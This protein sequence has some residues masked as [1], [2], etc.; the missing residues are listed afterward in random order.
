MKIALVFSWPSVDATKGNLLSEWESKVTNELM[1]QAG[2]VPTKQLAAYPTHV[3]KPA[4][5]FLGKYYT[6]P[7]MTTL[8]AREKLCKELAGFDIALTM[9]TFAMWALTGETKLDIFRG[10]HIDSPFVPGLQVV[11][12]YD[13]EVFAR[14][15][16]SARPVVL[17]AMRKAQSKYEDT[18][19]DIY[20]PESLDDLTW[21]EKQFIRDEIAFDVE[22]NG[23]S[24]IT[25]FSVVPHEDACLYVALE[26][27]THAS[28]H[29]EPTELGI[30]SWLNSLAR[31]TDL[32]W[33][34][35]NATYDL[36]YLDAYGIH[37]LGHI[38]D[39]M[40]VHHAWQPEWEKSLGF[41]AAMH[42]KGRAWKHFR[43]VAKKN[44]NK[45][46]AL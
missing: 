23:A 29:D 45:A 8:A 21:F 20:V 24:R 39:T 37:P 9:G 25:E 36:T 43:Q 31:R 7:T 1:K 22:T 3:K 18:L 32:T 2:F 5:L 26:T 15:D 34:M 6:Q 33:I 38:Y 12:T 4:S 27:P 44:I 30:F 35:Q 10:T 19:F 40:L 11:P 17:S 13:P 46:G 42:L 28:V 16:W 41:M 14:K